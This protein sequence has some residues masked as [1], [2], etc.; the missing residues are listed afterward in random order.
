MDAQ[1]LFHIDVKYCDIPTSFRQKD[2]FYFIAI[3]K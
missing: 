2:F 3:Q 1:Y